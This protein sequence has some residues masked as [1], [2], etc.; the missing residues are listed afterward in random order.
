MARKKCC[1]FCRKPVRRGDY[2]EASGFRMHVECLKKA[3]LAREG[4]CTQSQPVG[5]DKG[6]PE[7]PASGLTAHNLRFDTGSPRRETPFKGV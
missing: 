2:L 7:T 1:A 6:C 5:Y 3:R 4:T